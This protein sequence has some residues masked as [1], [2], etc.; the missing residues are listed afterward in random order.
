MHGRGQNQRTDQLRLMLTMHPLHFS[1]TNKQCLRGQ[2]W[3]AAP[4]SETLRAY[5]SSGMS[6]M[7]KTRI[8]QASSPRVH[9]ELTGSN[10]EESSLSSHPRTLS[11]KAQPSVG[12]AAPLPLP[13]SLPQIL[14]PDWAQNVTHGL[15]E[16]ASSRTGA[17]KPVIPPRPPANKLFCGL[18]HTSGLDISVQ[19]L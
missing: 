13:G 5:L 11:T 3:K 2:S 1:K 15:L 7:A 10:R 16:L 6:R 18:L 19:S 9:G 8:S 4:T 14:K 12:T 17:D